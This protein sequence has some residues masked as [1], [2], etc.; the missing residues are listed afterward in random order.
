[1]AGELGKIGD[2]GAVELAVID[3]SRIPPE[4]R[5]ELVAK[6]MGVLKAAISADVADEEHVIAVPVVIRTTVQVRLGKL[7]KPV[8]GI[9]NRT[10]DVHIDLQDIRTQ[11]TAQVNDPADVQPGEIDR[12]KQYDIITTILR[13]G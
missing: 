8:D 9:Y 6:D 10:A 12:A 11:A 4:L 7:P 13:N 2:G 5:A 3:A 1:M